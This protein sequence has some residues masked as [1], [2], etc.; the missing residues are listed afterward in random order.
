MHSA[1]AI[2]EILSAKPHIWLFISINGTEIDYKLP[3]TNGCKEA[4][5]VVK[6]LRHTADEIEELIV[7]FY[8]V[9]KAITE[10]IDHVAK[11][12]ERQANG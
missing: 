1:A 10:A 4:K 6:M 12:K 7:R 3:L 8:A 5:S 11:T 2:D 9:E